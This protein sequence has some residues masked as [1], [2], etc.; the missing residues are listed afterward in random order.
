MEDVDLLLAS[1]GSQDADRTWIILQLSESQDERVFELYL[2]L[3]R[4]SGEEDLVRIEVLKSLVLRK[5]SQLNRERMANAIIAIVT[6]EDDDLVRQY[7]AR[8]LRH[9]IDI[10]RV[11]EVAE[12]TVMNESDDIDVRYNALAA[13]QMNRRDSRCHAALRRLVDVP[14]LGTAARRTLNR[15]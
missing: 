9:F 4:D 1:F 15:A 8:A 7:A 11:L 13:I 2:G 14:E 5:D 6:G 3:V 12:A 10:R